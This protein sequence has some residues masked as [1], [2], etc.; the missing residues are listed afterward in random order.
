MKFTRKLV[1]DMSNHFPGNLP[2]MIWAREHQ[3]SAVAIIHQDLTPM[4]ATV[5][6]MSGK[7]CGVKYDRASL[8][9]YCG[10]SVRV[11]EIPMFQRD[12]IFLYVMS[13]YSAA[14]S[15]EERAFMVDFVDELIYS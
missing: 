1:Q 3:D 6:F 12:R 13:M 7:M 14:L 8:T 10:D 11:K 2:K 4:E 5:E 15:K 9:L